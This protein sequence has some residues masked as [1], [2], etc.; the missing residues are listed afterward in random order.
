VVTELTQ[1]SQTVTVRNNLT[2][3]PTIEAATP[4][5]AQLETQTQTESLPRTPGTENTAATPA[6]AESI[7]VAYSDTIAAI[8]AEGKAT[9]LT[10]AATEPQPMDV[11]ESKAR[12]TVPPSANTTVKVEKLNSTTVPPLPTSSENDP[13]FSTTSDP[14]EFFDK[15]FTVT[16]TDFTFSTTDQ[17]Q[18]TSTS[19]EAFFTDSTAST[20]LPETS[21]VFSAT[22]GFS[23][24]SRLNITTNF[25]L[26]TL[27]PLFNDSSV[28]DFDFTT[29]T[30]FT[31]PFSSFEATDF[32]NSSTFFNTLVNFID[33]STQSVKDLIGFGKNSTTLESTT[34]PSVPPS[35]A[36]KTNSSNN[37]A[38]G[39]SVSQ[40]STLPVNVS[41][42]QNDAKEASK[43]AFR[44]SMLR[45]DNAS[46]IGKENVD[47]RTLPKKSISESNE[48]L[49][50]AINIAAESSNAELSTFRTPPNYVNVLSVKQSKIVSSKY[51]IR[52]VKGSKRR[53]VRNVPVQSDQ[54]YNNTAEIIGNFTETVKKLQDGLRNVST[55]TGG[56]YSSY[57]VS[58][59]AESGG[60]DSTKAYADI[61]DFN[62]DIR[63]VRSY[64]R[65][66]HSCVKS[67]NLKTVTWNPIRLNFSFYT[68]LSSEQIIR[69]NR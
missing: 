17:S 27:T 18:Q 69:I 53:F 50:G 6:A 63:S 67:D 22:L 25:T 66:L 47:P 1:T 10:A 68:L 15:N 11:A 65:K 42:S 61:N 16:F 56:N 26:P 51:D 19:F 24:A 45:I 37:N 32:G 64:G 12:G 21:T 28:A 13:Q 34:Q 35:A 57:S 46:R 31:S 36:D 29:F 8:P 38:G 4:G 23:P 7:T 3:L 41:A 58:L 9:V 43:A 60:G 48:Y 20:L 52:S 33:S 2:S 30:P 55:P 44:S 59:R 49:N 62:G 14:N 54:A 5:F 40:N 39:P